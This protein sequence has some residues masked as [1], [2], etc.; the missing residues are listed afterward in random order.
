MTRIEVLGAAS[1]VDFWPAHTRSLSTRYP[2]SLSLI[3]ARGLHYCTSTGHTVGIWLR[4]MGRETARE[5]GEVCRG[6]VGKVSGSHGAHG[7]TFSPV[8]CAVL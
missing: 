1:C 5:A 2:H 3:T 6:G 8:S 7:M 4:E